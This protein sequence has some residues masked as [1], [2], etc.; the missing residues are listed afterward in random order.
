MAENLTSDQL[1]DL[2]VWAMKTPFMAKHYSPRL[3]DRERRVLLLR[4]GWDYCSIRECEKCWELI[5]AHTFT[6]WMTPS[7][8]NAFWV[9]PTREERMAMRQDTDAEGGF[10]DP[11][12]QPVQ[13]TV[14]R[15][16]S[17]FP[18][19]DFHWR[20]PIT[21]AEMLHQNTHQKAWTT[22]PHTLKEIGAEL[23]GISGTR[24][25]QIEAKAIRKNRHY[26]NQLWKKFTTMVEAADVAE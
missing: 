16:I 23:G 2:S 13:V 26:L 11:F 19:E 7:N 4:Y 9:R 14:T 21:V 6:E 15:S 17:G 10:I 3:N 12:T 20:L 22:K 8:T 25:A 5:P 1:T 18:R 24:V